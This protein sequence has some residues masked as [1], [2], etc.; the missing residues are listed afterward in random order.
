[1]LDLRIY[2]IKLV[3]NKITFSSIKTQKIYKFEE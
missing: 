3:Y 1:M 2:F